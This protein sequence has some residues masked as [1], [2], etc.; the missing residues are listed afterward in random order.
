MKFKILAS[1]LV[2]LGEAHVSP[3]KNDYGFNG[4]DLTSSIPNAGGGG[5]GVGTDIIDA[6]ITGTIALLSISALFLRRKSKK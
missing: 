2:D 6:P 3:A 4:Y 5:I 1:L